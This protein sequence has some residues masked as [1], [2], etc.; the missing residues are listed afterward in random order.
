MNDPH[1]Q[2]LLE[3]TT[4]DEWQ[5]F[6]KEEVKEY[7]ENLE[8]NAIY[9]CSNVEMVFKVKG[10]LEILNWL[11]TLEDSVKMRIEQEEINND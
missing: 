2:K 5:Y 8:K 11:L 3:V 10:K 7:K 9:S 6:I 4:S 1:L